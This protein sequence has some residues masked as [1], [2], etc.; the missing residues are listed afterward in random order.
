ML[1][2]IIKG[3]R[4][5]AVYMLNFDDLVKSGEQLKNSPQNG[6]KQ[7]GMF[8][9]YVSLSSNW[10]HDGA[11]CVKTKNAIKLLHNDK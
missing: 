11:S 1:H 8:S 3:I 10:Q 6:Y 4:H 9:V 5:N 7:N 2:I